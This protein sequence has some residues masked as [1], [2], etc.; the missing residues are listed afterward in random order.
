MASQE[1][2]SQESANAVPEGAVPNDSA[3]EGPLPAASSL[4]VQLLDRAIMHGVIDLPGARRAEKLLAAGEAENVTDALQQLGVPAERA[5]RFD[6][7]AYVGLTAGG[8]RLETP[9]GVGGVGYVFRGVQ[10]SLSRAVAVKVLDPEL[11]ELPHVR[12]RFRREAEAAAQLDHPHVVQPIDFG[13]ED[14]LFFFAMEFLPGGS[15][16]EKIEAGPLEEAQA[17]AVARDIADALVYA[18]QKGIVHR[19]IK[20]ANVLFDRKGRAALADLGLAL[21][22]E[23]QATRLTHEGMILGSP[24]YIA[25]E[26]VLGEVELDGRADQ[27]ALGVTLFEMLSGRP[28]IEG[29]TAVA[30]I[31]QHLSATWPRLAEV[32]PQASRRTQALIDRMGARN[33]DER[34]ETPEAMLSAIEAARDA[35]ARGAPDLETPKRLPADPTS[36]SSEVPEPTEPP[37]PLK[38]R[39]GHL[40]LTGLLLLAGLLGWALWRGLGTPAQEAPASPQAPAYGPIQA[41]DADALIALLLER[42]AFDGGFSH[43]P[44]VSASPWATAQAYCALAAHPESSPA[45]LRGELLR[46]VARLAITEP[47]PS[48]SAIITG[49]S[50][51]PEDT[52]SVTE[53]S[54]WGFTAAALA[55]DAGGKRPDPAPRPGAGLESVSLEQARRSLLGLQAPSGGFL[56]V[57]AAGESSVRSS[58]SAM[59]L[60]ALATVESVSGSPSPQGLSAVER[61]ARFLGSAYDS[62]H[63]AW[64]P[65]PTQAWGARAE[66]HGLSEAVAYAL[67][68]AESLLTRAGRELPS[69]ATS[70]LE[71]YSATFREVG[72]PID[73]VGVARGEDY[74]FPLPAEQRLSLTGL[75]WVHYPWRLL[76]AERLSRRAGS[77]SAAWRAEAARLRAALPELTARLQDRTPFQVAECAFA[78]QLLRR[79]EAAGE[80]AAT[81]SL[82]LTLNP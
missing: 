71:D 16:A 75:R 81:G 62:R 7:G 13:D 32:A 50:G 18:E 22:V 23:T 53:G 46:H 41:G 38:R 48:G 57:P 69:E 4:V 11:A 79:A 9:L 51:R 19:D 70:A 37:E 73:A 58:G 17:L 2:Q 44:D 42:R 34:F 60:I 54:F 10:Q 1:P 63:R 33:R 12:E 35:L 52:A 59:A 39:A 3:P 72:V 20:P 24:F 21:R 45:A 27:Y 80:H 30:V 15:L 67:C 36:G 28:P 26:Q 43:A 74:Y 25:P 8:F 64:Y 66:V 29:K 5:R 31:Q 49:W 65:N 68:E 56:S 77:A 6:L 82:V 78:I 61:G 47:A 55:V 40:A 14:G 76:A